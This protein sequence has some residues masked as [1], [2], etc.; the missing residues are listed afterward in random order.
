MYV[1]G[2]QEGRRRIQR[3]DVRV[4]VIP[5]YRLRIELLDTIKVETRAE[6]ERARPGG[7]AAAA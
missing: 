3:A 6:F 4:D 1:C 2:N 5:G 7:K